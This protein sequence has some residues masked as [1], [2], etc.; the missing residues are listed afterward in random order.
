MPVHSSAV[1]TLGTPWLRVWF[2]VSIRVFRN[3]TTWLKLRCSGSTYTLDHEGFAA[4]SQSIAH[5]HG[6]LPES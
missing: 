4:N 1:R 6:K 5:W 2:L 3:L